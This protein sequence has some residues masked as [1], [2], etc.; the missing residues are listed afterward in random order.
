MQLDATD[1][2]VGKLV[3]QIRLKR[4]MSAS[5]RVKIAFMGR[6]LAESQSLAD[7]G[8]KDGDVLSVLLVG[9]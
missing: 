4:G 1:L 6:V 2:A 7:Y 9:I 3:Q 5:A 8:W